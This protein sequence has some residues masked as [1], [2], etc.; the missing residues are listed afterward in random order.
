MIINL[1]KYLILGSETDLDRF[2]SRAQAQG[3]LEFI[4]L[5]PK[6]KVAHKE[7]VEHLFS[8]LKILKKLPVAKPYVGGGDEAEALHICSRILF[9][10]KEIEK[11]HEEER[12]LRQEMARVAPFGDF[13]LEDIEYIEKHGHRKVQFFCMRTAKSHATDIPDEVIYIGTEFDLDY[14]MTINPELRHY[15]DM[16]EMRIDRPL[17]DLKLHLSCAND[18][19]KSMEKELKDFSGYIDFLNHI[20]VELLNDHNLDFAKK[21]VAYPLENSV[22][23]VEAWIPE[24]KVG[25]LFAMIDGMSIHAEE[26]L[27]EPEDKIP[28]CMENAGTSK[29]GEDLVKIYDIPSTSDKDPSPWVFWVF[30]LFFSMIVSDAG[31]GL[32]YL[33]I[34]LYCKWKFPNLTGVGK[35]FLNL[36]VILSC[37]C[38]VW[39]VLTAAYFGLKVDSQSF[40]G[41]ISILKHIA[42]AKAEYAMQAANGVAA[43]VQA[44]SSSP[45]VLSNEMLDQYS[46]DVLL[47]FSLMVG[48]IHISFSFLRY[49]RRSW[50]GIGWIAFMMGGYLF[51]PSI[52]H[53]TSLIN[54]FGWVTPEMGKE[55]GLQLMYGGIGAAVIL[56][57][58]QKRS[59]ALGEITNVVQVFADVL[60]YLRLYALA[61]AGSIMAETFNGIGD[62][63][64]LV[65]GIVATIVGHLVNIL[66]GIMA[67]VIH[68]LRLNFLEW[69]HY[70]FDGN[71]R[72]FK[73]LKK[74]KSRS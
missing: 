12:L 6:N 41:K 45:I 4:S 37:G 43:H 63:I 32:L 15:P 42:A 11:L 74:L 1:K 46:R 66:L 70:S 24:N 72:L 60:S 35:R 9:L 69:Y 36:F 71:G 29:M 26:I 47:E 59:Q 18:S 10:H 22:F 33:A 68:G 3:F 20:L 38:I 57:F 8:A 27:I 49:I 44:V 23:A 48:V 58:I 17:G 5:N 61:L 16:I 73:P 28:T 34:A 50:A 14:F 40:F 7:D 30:V 67:G 65:A 52:L 51:F 31:Y 25:T 19:L 54:V 56:A 62:Y 53:A 55:L 2:F 64:G 39:G 13:S 21:D